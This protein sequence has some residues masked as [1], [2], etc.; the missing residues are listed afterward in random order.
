MDQPTQLIF[1][2]WFVSFGCCRSMLL[3]VLWL[4]TKWMFECV[5][6]MAAA[7]WTRRKSIRIGLHDGT[8]IHEWWNGK[9]NNGNSVILFGEVHSPRICTSKGIIVDRRIELQWT[10]LSSGIQW[11]FLLRWFWWM[12]EGK[13]LRGIKRLCRIPINIVM[14]LWTRRSVLWNDDSLIDSY[15]IFFGRRKKN[16]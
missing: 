11:L 14:W 9:A 13:R 16:E 4:S 1:C 7:R 2:F 12:E 15:H 6:L 3:C 10:R 5:S 8:F